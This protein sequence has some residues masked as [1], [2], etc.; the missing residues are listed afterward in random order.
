MILT[1]TPY[2]IILKEIQNE[3]EKVWY[4]ERK[5]RTE[6]G[7][8]F[9]KNPVLP[10][11]HYKTYTVPKSKN[12]Y[13]IWYYADTFNQAFY[14][15]F[16]GGWCLLL[17]E[18]NGK[19]MIYSLAVTPVERFSNVTRDTLISFTGH[20]FSRYRER[21][22][23]PDSVSPIEL[24]VRYI[25]RNGEVMTK[26]EFEQINTNTEQYPDGVAYQV[27]DGIILGTKKE[28]KDRNGNPFA[29]IKHNTFLD[30]GIL[31][32]NQKKAM[33]NLDVIKAIHELNLT[34][35]QIKELKKH[36]KN[37]SA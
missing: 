32:S 20:F 8:A 36:D 27:R 30:N 9:L 11:I 3:S 2:D 18:D 5:G 33:Q 31:K 7:K 19:R 24:I 4:H 16:V 25:A 15:R 23:F 1:K 14:E 6:A 35:E 13:L 10:F 26:L 12:T 22:N 21:M 29:V 28:Y 34:P 17:N 37:D